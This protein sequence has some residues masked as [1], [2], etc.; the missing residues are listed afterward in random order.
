M[1]KIEGQYRQ[2]DVLIEEIPVSE[3]PPKA[4]KTKG[5]VILAEGEATGHAHEIA[6]SDGEAWK[7]GAD[8]VAVTVKRKTPVKHQEHAPI[9]LKKKSHRIIRQREYHPESIRRVAD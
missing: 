6:E 2:G 5:R 7:I 9:P 4:V 1:K 3:I 8:V